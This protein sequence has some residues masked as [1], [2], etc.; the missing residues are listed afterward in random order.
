[1]KLILLLILLTTNGLATLENLSTS[2]PQDQRKQSDTFLL[3]NEQRR[4]KNPDGLIFSL[5]L[6]DKQ[7]RFYAGEIIPLELSFSSSIDGRFV[8]DNAGYDRSGRLDIDSFI[9]DHSDGTV[10]PLEDYF[11][12]GLF[13]FIGGGLR[14]MPELSEKPVIITA[15]LNEWIRFDKP[16]RYRLY[17]V[18]SR[19]SPKRNPENPFR[20]E[21]SAVVSNV[22]EFDILR[23]DEKWANQKLREALAALERKEAD[24][25][26]APASPDA[27][28]RAACRTLRF[29]G[30]V[31]AASQMVRRFSGNDTDCDFD[32]DFGLIS[33]PHRDFIIRE[34]E[35]VLRSPE[36]AVT[37]SF[38]RTLS[39]LAFSTRVTAMPDYPVGNDEQI[40][41][42]QAQIEQRRH[43]YNEVALE[44]LRQLVAVVPQK[45][46]RAR[47]RSLQTL[48]DY[49][50]TLKSTDLTESKNLL[51]T[52]PDV[53]GLLRL[54]AQTR[55]LAYQWKPI[56]S[57]AMLPVLRGILKQADNKTNEQRELRSVAL[58]RLYE[59]S[60][61]EGRQLIIEEIGRPNPR[62]QEGVL[63]S[64]R[65]ENL[66]EL[67]EILATNLEQ[68]HGPNGRGNAEAISD[69]VER[70]A[71]SAILGR[72]RAVYEGPGVGKWACRIQASL[73]AF[74]LRYDPATGGE[75]L[76]RALTARD[77]GLS[78]CY[79][80]TLIDVAALQNSPEVEDAANALLQESDPEIV[81]EA[82][83]VLG[84]YGSADAEERLWKRLEKW[85]A[86]L[87]SQAIAIR[88]ENPGLPEYGSSRLSGEALI[89]QALRGA[90]SHGKS[91]LSDPKK[92]TRLQ[93]L[94][95]TDGCRN[96]LDRMI[97]SWNRDIHFRLGSFEDRPYYISVA[98]YELN[99]LEGLKQK[100]IQFPKGTLFTWQT[101]VADGDI[102]RE[103]EI[104]QQI[105][106]YLEE[107][108]MKLERETK[109]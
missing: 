20:K 102:S 97:S 109:Q 100:L 17:V 28:R 31:E 108:G 85:H 43:T 69:L 24:R 16:G 66:A 89:E 83:R 78:R 34:M 1:M 47:A 50:E 12:S 59:L 55:L 23:A 33:S 90:I 11:H 6:K 64:L 86:E 68:A 62:V 25:K 99:S 73:L 57:A 35:R 37:T 38:I 104:F 14:G 79:T 106:S 30:T 96:E 71:T 41:Q 76:N 42:W 46:D 40:K 9:L 48:L 94:C 98:H 93:G 101:S 36:H 45:H 22:V 54:E 95:L 27:D 84:Q 75:L 58:R 92:L 7:T 103:Q 88:H 19:I 3:Q 53:F 29:L 5:R 74:I 10:D 56:A 49:Q 82:A 39:L 81:S 67:D 107:Y 32:H 87:Q 77:K 44:Y 4:A 63:R 13:G 26:A 52:L 70:Y 21:N 51:S 72:V 61:G 80:S 65:D 2:S 15:E 60:P 91:W 105:K 18:S 8:L